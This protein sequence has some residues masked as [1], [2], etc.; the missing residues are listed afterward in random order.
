MLVIHDS[1][2]MEILSMETV[3]WA[4]R[5]INKYH[6]LREFCRSNGHDCKI[7]PYFTAD[8]KEEKDIF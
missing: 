3:A 5:G 1:G 4:D 2:S 8:H 6:I 7:I